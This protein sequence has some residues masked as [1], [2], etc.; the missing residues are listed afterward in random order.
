MG[1]DAIGLR[2]LKRKRMIESWMA[3]RRNKKRYLG[4]RILERSRFTVQMMGMFVNKSKRRNM[5]LR[6]IRR[7]LIILVYLFG[8]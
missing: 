5:I 3:K 2:R 8:K 7:V 4:Q 6:M 1:S